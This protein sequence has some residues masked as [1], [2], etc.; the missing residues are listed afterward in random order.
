M[1][2]TTIHGTE[3]RD[4]E[5]RAE[6]LVSA[7]H[8]LFVSEGYDRTGLDELAHRAGLD[9]DEARELFPDKQAVFAALIERGIRIA[10]V[11]GPDVA[12]GVDEDLPA[13]LARTYLTLWEPRDGEESP[14]VRLYRIGLSSPEASAVLRE[15][16]TRA[17][18]SQVDGELPCEDGA[19][20]T[21]AFGAH[22]GGLAV[23][24]HLIGIGPLAQAPLS[25][26]LELVTPSLR[27]ELLAG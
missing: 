23:W 9:P 13:R 24:R 7:A 8:E 27:R 18:N 11:L 19:L 3:A 2:T 20:R 16:V 6:A 5:Q 14:M 26:L 22:V 17:L 15:R 21:A 4:R 1:S 10:G 25:E 12:Q